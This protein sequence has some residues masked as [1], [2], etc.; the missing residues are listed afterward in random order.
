MAAEGDTT[1]L[2][3]PEAR[4]DDT[5]DTYHGVEVA[6]PYRWLEDPDSEETAAWVTAQNE[7]TDKVLAA[8]T[9]RDKIR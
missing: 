1:G 3:Y 6:D 9:F 5:K 4:R 2:A 7:V 8:C